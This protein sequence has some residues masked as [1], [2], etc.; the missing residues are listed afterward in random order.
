MN[1]FI[2]SKYLIFYNMSIIHIFFRVFQIRE[3]FFFIINFSNKIRLYMNLLDISLFIL[4]NNWFLSSSKKL[5]I[6][7]RFLNFLIFLQIFSINHEFYSFLS[8]ILYLNLRLNFLR[9]VLLTN[10]ANKH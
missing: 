2:I 8:F 10:L 1:L 7:T 4:F 9:N 5:F 3:R 6:I